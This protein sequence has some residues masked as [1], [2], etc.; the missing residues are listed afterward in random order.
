[1]V[2]CRCEII[3]LEG[4]GGKTTPTHRRGE[5]KTQEGIRA[6]SKK[7]VRIFGFV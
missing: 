1:M 7:T 4:T 3:G 5:V 6:K 2:E